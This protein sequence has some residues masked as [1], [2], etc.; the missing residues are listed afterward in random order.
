MLHIVQ[1]VQLLRGNLDAGVSTRKTQDLRLSQSN[2][3]TLVVS[4]TLALGEAP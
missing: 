3:C 4:V 1:H 2:L